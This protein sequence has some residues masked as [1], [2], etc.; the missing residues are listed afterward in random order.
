MSDIP[1]VLTEVP[2]RGALMQRSG[3]FALFGGLLAA[4]IFAGFA[5]GG[6]G[7]FNTTT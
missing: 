5:I 2:I 1:G 6:F 7:G 3:L 4:A